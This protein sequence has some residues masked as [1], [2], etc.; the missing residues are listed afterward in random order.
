MRTRECVSCA[1]MF[2]CKGK[3]NASP[4]LNYKKYEPPKKNK[5]F[6]ERLSE[7]YAD[8][9]ELQANKSNRSKQ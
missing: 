4:C 8:D 3:D 6:F 7:R 2:E 5:S 9:N 1:K